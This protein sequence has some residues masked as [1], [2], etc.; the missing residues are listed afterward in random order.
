MVMYEKNIVHFHNDYKTLAQYP[1]HPARARMDSWLDAVPKNTLRWHVN[2]WPSVKVLKKPVQ[3]FAL[4]G[5]WHKLMCQALEQ[6]GYGTDGRKLGTQSKGLAGT[7]EVVV[8]NQSGFMDS[9]SVLLN[10]CLDIVAA[11][12]AEQTKE[13]GRINKPATSWRRVSLK[14]T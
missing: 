9:E 12:E 5:K 3:R 7:L 1:L 2:T 14:R 4:Q 11:I 10:K 8:R 13:T 6:R